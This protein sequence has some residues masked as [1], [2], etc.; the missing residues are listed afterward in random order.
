[1]DDPGTELA[2][3][4]LQDKIGEGGMGV[5]YR[6]WDTRLE[7]TVAIKILPPRVR[8]DPERRAR[9]LREA[10]AAA[11]LN[12][13]N[14]A[15]VYEVGEAAVPAGA[16]GATE[17]PGP[18]PP[19]EVLYLAM[20]Y[21]AGEDLRT[22]AA[23][24]P[25]PEEEVLD[26]ALQVCDGLAAAHGAG[27]VHR[28]LK[29]P[30]LR[31]TP[32]GRVKILD[33][34][35][36]KLLAEDGE[37]GTPEARFQTSDGMILGTAPYMAPEQF[38]GEGVD[39]RVDLFA[40]GVILY[41]LA[42]GRLPFDS[43]NLVRYVRSLSETTPP[44]LSGLR[45]GLSPGLAE[46]IHRL[47]AKDREERVSS[48]AELRAGLAALRAVPRRRR[49]PV[50]FWR[51]SRWLAPG[52]RGP[53]AASPRRGWWLTG[54]TLA[55]VAV[56]AVAVL[57]PRWRPA[58]PPV[59]NLAVLPFENQ[60]DDPSLTAYY[61]GIGTALL[62][63]LS[64]IPG[65]NVVAELDVRRYRGTE[66]TSEE[67]AR[68]LD[69]G[70]L[71]QGYVQGRRERLVVGV[72]M[73]N[74]APHISLW[75][76]T[77]E[78]T[79]DGLPE[80]QERIADGVLRQLPVSLSQRER[81]R[82]RA[83]PTASREAWDAYFQGLAL[84]EQVDDPAALE[85]AAEHL[86]RAVELDPQFAWAW[87]DL[88]EALWRGFRFS[89]REELLNEAGAAASSAVEL[90]AQEPLFRV[91][92]ARVERGRGRFSQARQFLEEALRLNPVSD[93][94]MREL[95]SVAAEEGKLEKAKES[96][97]SAA[98]LRPS[99]WGSWNELGTFLFRHSRYAEAEEALEQARKLAPP[100]VVR[101]LENL[102]SLALVQGDTALALQRYEEIPE[103]L[104]T[105]SLYYNLGVLNLTS[106]QPRRAIPALRNAI[107]KNPVE[108]T[109]RI[110]LADV[111]GRQGDHHAAEEQYLEGMRSLEAI[112][113][114]NPRS[115]ERRALR[116]YLLSR[117]NRCSQ[118][119][120]AAEELE[121]QGG[122][123][124]EHRI[125]LAR[126]Y[127]VCDDRSSVRRLLQDLMR[128]GVPQERL[129]SEV[130]LAEY[131]EEDRSQPGP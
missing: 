29:P 39:P 129:A 127:A 47:L 118:S 8:R 117:L 56:A 116:A 6:A 115:L 113:A 42:S 15:T 107:E 49:G 57:G 131:L 112:L 3:Y 77:F 11:R 33:F 98:R 37:S 28:D 87:A 41:Q 60:T 76:R 46:L 13:P 99:Y 64:R 34:G 125:Y 53:G 4:K 108:P 80:L 73:T 91:A 88:S 74:A 85:R 43:S 71:I 122:V 75:D 100:E 126:A 84:L 109:Y 17:V 20:E 21:V 31:L 36:A 16:L 97:A 89:K 55:V 111:L 65:V 82:L 54:G 78:G 110:V 105:A 90:D 69:V 67:I 106:G 27:V 121:K 103:H 22:A 101:P 9:F 63:Q 51:P 10:R 45:P 58:A 52:S 61:E 19:V 7:R 95:G 130:E 62:R 70:T 59:V 40:L 18:A 81:Q 123:P 119:K 44:P 102:A 66:K 12:H 114:T 124:D 35:L 48:A 30:N 5:V 83:H 26:L 38:Q 68:E 120:N 2:H 128:A 94:V 72:Q 92:Q 50:P 86:R 1:M 23:R 24:A 14:I 104:R 93:L 25:L 32:E 96:F 79:A